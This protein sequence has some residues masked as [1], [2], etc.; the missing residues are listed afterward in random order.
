M[1]HFNCKCMCFAL[2]ARI[3]N[4]NGSGRLIDSALGNTNQHVP[5]SNQNQKESPARGH[6]FCPGNGF[7]SRPIEDCLHDSEE[8][9]DKTLNDFFL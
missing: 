4:Q 2:C 9:W 6:G 7:D 5:I 1:E 3:S 8:V